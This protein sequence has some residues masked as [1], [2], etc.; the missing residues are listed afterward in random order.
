MADFSSHLRQNTTLRALALEQ[1]Q[2]HAMRTRAR[3]AAYQW[4]GKAPEGILILEDL[5]LQTLLTSA[6]DRWALSQH[7][8]SPS[9]K[10]HEWQAM[11]QEEYWLYQGEV[12]LVQRILETIA[13]ATEA[14]D[15]ERDGGYQA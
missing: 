3:K 4:F 14:D 9:A 15:G 1:A 5:V 6:R 13:Q 7:A 12:R 2:D 11:P 10:P 8:L